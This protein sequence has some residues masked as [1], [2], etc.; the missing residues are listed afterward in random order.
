MLLQDSHAVSESETSCDTCVVACETELRTQCNQSSPD[1]VSMQCG[2]KEMAL[3]G[4]TCPTTVAGNVS[5]MEHILHASSHISA[6]ACFC[7]PVGH[8][9][10]HCSNL[11]LRSRCYL[12]RPDGADAPVSAGFIAAVCV[13][14][15]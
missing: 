13:H 8:G 6:V 3:L 1:F 10:C 4:E 14:T 2:C 9:M 7:M 5:V 15:D 11:E 12:S